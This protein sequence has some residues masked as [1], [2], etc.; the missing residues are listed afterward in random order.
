MPGPDGPWGEAL[1]AAVR[2]GRGPRGR[3]RPQGVPDPAAGRPG[4]RL[5]GFEP[6]RPNRWPSRTH[7]VRPRGRRRGHGDGAQRRRAAV[8]ACRPSPRLRSSVTTPAYARTQGGGCATVVP[9]QM[10]TP[11]DG[12]RAAFRAPTSLTGGRGG[13]GGHR[14]AAAG[15]DH[16][17]GHR[18]PGVLVRFL[19]ANGN[20]LFAEDRRS[21]ALVWFGGDAPIAASATVELHTH[22]T[23]DETGAVRLGFAAVGTWPRSSSTASAAR[24]GHRRS[25]RNRPR[26]RVPG[27]AVRVRCRSQCDRR[28]AARGPDRTGHCRPRRCRCPT[29]WRSPSASSPTTADPDGLIAEAVEAAAAAEIAVVVVGTNSR[30]ESEGYDRP[31]WNCRAGRTTW[32]TPS[33]PRTPAR[34]WS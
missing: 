5:E 12:I 25:G 34:S 7:R 9:E 11:L 13:A 3:G 6:R 31:R 28:V 10:V 2:V 26:R 17:P 22:Y 29:P 27:P 19:D 1:V 8:D 18:D 30:V 20:E 16:Q 33:P 21:T 14:R 4:G 32:S 15:A 24:R 23:P